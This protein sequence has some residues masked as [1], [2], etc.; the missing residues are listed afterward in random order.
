V[1]KKPTNRSDKSSVDRSWAFN[2]FVDIALS[3]VPGAKLLFISCLELKKEIIMCG[4]LK[5]IFA[6]NGFCRQLCLVLPTDRSTLIIS[7]NVGLVVI[8]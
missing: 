3:S 6:V 5:H 4:T 1:S 7:S 2:I 8:Y